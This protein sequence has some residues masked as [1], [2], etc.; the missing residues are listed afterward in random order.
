M[1]SLRVAQAVTVHRNTQHFA[2][3]TGKES[4]LPCNTE[5]SNSHKYHIDH[6]QYVI[7]QPL[8]QPNITETSPK[9]NKN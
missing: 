4:W 5:H 7:V 6:Y 3:K 2:S 1:A 8:H 9:K